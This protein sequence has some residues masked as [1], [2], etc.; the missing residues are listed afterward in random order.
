MIHHPIILYFKLDLPFFVVEILGIH[1]TPSHIIICNVLF[2]LITI[3]KTSSIVPLFIKNCNS[4]KNK[5]TDENTG[6]K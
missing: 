5:N 6:S 2:N 4:K 3:P 1:P